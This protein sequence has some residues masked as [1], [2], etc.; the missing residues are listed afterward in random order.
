[1][2]A[3]GS[4]R[5]GEATETVFSISFA[6]LALPCVARFLR[7]FDWCPD[8]IIR[9]MNFLGP[10]FDWTGVLGAVAC[11]L[12]GLFIFRSRAGLAALSILY[13]TICLMIM[14]LIVSGR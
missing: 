12:W 4:T 11:I 14:P 3:V 10:W 8:W 5:K 6:L 9:T 13:G 7:N 1:M 2:K